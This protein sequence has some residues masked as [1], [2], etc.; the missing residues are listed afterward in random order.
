MSADK[1]TLWHIRISHY[2]EKARWALDHKGVDHRKMAPPPGAHMAVAAALTRGRSVT[3]PILQI[4]GTAVADSS[5][6]IAELERRFPNNPLYPSDAGELRRA[7]ALEDYFDETL[8]P[9]IRRYSWHFLSGDPELIGKALADDLPSVLARS[10]FARAGASRFAAGFVRLRYR[11]RDDAGAEAA[12]RTVL[13]AL[14]RLERE[15]G[16]NEYLVGDSFSVADLA[17]AS[18]FYPLVAPPEGPVQIERPAALEQFRSEQS[19]RAGFKWVEGIF[20]RH[21]RKVPAAA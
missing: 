13:A 20:A 16:D 3:F 4:D 14:D 2:S 15:L 18:L 6:I 17:A 10:D 1:P 11:A 7:L 5:E 21:R 12:K 9:A 19:S 8:G